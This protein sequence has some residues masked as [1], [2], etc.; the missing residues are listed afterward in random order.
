MEEPRG[1]VQKFFVRN[2]V[3]ALEEGSG[4]K[5]EALKPRGRQTPRLFLAESLPKEIPQEAFKLSGG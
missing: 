2:T 3:K 4:S 1:S 5:H